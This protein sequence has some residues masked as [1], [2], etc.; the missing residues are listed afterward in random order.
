[1]AKVETASSQQAAVD[2]GDWTRLAP[3]SVDSED[4]LG[5]DTVARDWQKMYDLAQLRNPNEVQR[6]AFRLAVYVYGVKNGTSREGAY[7]GEIQ[8]SDGFKF[9][10]SVV[11]QATGKMNIRK[12]FR[13]NMEESYVALKKSKAIENE[14]RVVAKAASL[15]IPAECAFA[16]ADWLTDCPDFTPMETAAH[17][18][19]FNRSVSRARRARGGHTLEDVEQDRI[20]QELDAQ[21]PSEPQVF[22][23]SVF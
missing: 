16:M 15:G 21:G 13:G 19:S 10:S 18:A 5:A 1:M 3:K 7:R 22:G 6:K 4:A 8:M 2:N 11:P 12:F 23:K 20:G 9:S 14:P 17:A